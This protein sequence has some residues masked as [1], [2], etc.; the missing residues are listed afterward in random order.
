[1]RRLVDTLYGRTSK[2]NKSAAPALPDPAS[3]SAN[4]PSNVPA[5]TESIKIGDVRT[6][7]NAFD[8]NDN[9]PITS[10]TDLTIVESD[11][12]MVSI[13]VGDLQGFVDKDFLLE[14]PQESK[15]I[16]SK[17]TL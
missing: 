10:G 12:K 4:N 11:D 8:T 3:P 15:L 5:N 16:I 17:I 6:A 9:I 1:M 2:Q 7:K 13:L 14:N